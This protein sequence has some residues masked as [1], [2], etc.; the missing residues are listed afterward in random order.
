VD[1]TP[2]RPEGTSLTREELPLLLPAGWDFDV[3]F[4]GQAAQA[5]KQG[6]AQPAESTETMDLPQTATGYA[7]LI[8]QGLLFLML[9]L[10]GLALRR[11]EARA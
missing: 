11:R 5:G 3:L 6:D 1:E 2:A 8:G 7:G 4:G 9:G 10:G